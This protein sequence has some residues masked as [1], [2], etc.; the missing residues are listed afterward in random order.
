LNIL[1]I[2]HYELTV[3]WLSRK[4]PYILGKTDEIRTKIERLVQQ[5]KLECFGIVRLGEDPDFPRFQEWMDRNLFA[6]MNF[7]K[8][9]QALRK[10]PRGLGEHLKTAIIVGMNY[11]QGDRSQS[12]LKLQSPIIAQYARLTDY[13][14][15]IRK[16]GERI[17]E[18]LSDV[19]G[20]PVSGRV[21]SDSAPI[22]ERSHAG[23][24]GS[25]FIG[26]NTCFIHPK[27]GSFFLLGEILIDADF[28]PTS[29]QVVDPSQRTSAGGCG[30]CMRCQVNC[31]TGALDEAWKL[32][33]NKCLSYWSIEHRGLIPIEYWKWF[34]IYLFGCDICQLVCPYNRGSE[35]T[36]HKELIKVEAVADLFRIAVMDQ[37]DY[38]FMFGGTPLTRAKKEGLIRNALIAMFV[39][40][41][42]KLQ[43]ALHFLSAS[44]N[45]DPSVAG[46]IEQIKTQIADRSV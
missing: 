46:T 28:S 33:A 38:E 8:N 7:L 30:T 15:V 3:T 35:Q 16:K 34:R 43:E 9:H 20:K 17:I 37:K 10:D 4:G 40:N 2:I 42:A 12:V 41:H 39:T 44:E 45:L 18:G 13:H 27:A 19:F 26:K 14:R 23:R 1:I 31:P 25:G 36:P 5:E 21:T 24:G 32:D 11:Y 22:L 6:G 29:D